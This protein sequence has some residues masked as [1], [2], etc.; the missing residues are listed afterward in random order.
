[1]NRLRIGGMLTMAVASVVLASCETGSESED[2]YQV[3]V[4]N[5]SS[6]PVVLFIDGDAENTVAP[7]DK[8]TE[9]VSDGEHAVSLRR[10]SGSVIF[11]QTINLN[12]STYV[13]YTVSPDGSVTA[14]GG[15]WDSN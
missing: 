9:T 6:A 2:Q 8:A 14:T 7:D 1:M 12:E 13:R 15:S 4:T 3:R 11:E 10:E 5:N